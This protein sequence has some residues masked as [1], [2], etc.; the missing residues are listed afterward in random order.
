MAR[1]EVKERCLVGGLIRRPGD[2]VEFEGDAPW[3]LKP[4]DEPAPEPV[5]E[6]PEV[7]EPVA[8]EAAETAPKR[9]PGRPRKT[10]S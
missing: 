10:Q 5:V 4:L 2:V 8:E 9:K 3:Y 1:Y 7:Q 6:E